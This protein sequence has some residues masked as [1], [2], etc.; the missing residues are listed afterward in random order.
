M[1]HRNSLL[2]G[3]PVCACNEVITLLLNG[4]LKGHRT[5]LMATV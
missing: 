3:C 4:R 2:F 1:L 5:I